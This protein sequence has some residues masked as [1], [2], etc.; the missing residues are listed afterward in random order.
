LFGGQLGDLAQACLGCLG[1]C[2]AGIVIG[3]LVIRAAGGLV[4]GGSSP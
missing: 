1:R 3:E 4:V 2:Q